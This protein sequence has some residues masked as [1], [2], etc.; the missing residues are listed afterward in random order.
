MMKIG[1]FWVKQNEPLITLPRSDFTKKCHVVHIMGLEDNHL[2]W[3]PSKEPYDCRTQV[4]PPIKAS[5]GGI[6][7]IAICF[8]WENKTVSF[9]GK[10]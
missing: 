2:L 1:H 7:W 9:A 3:T 10:S 6:Q 8:G 5:E 4:L